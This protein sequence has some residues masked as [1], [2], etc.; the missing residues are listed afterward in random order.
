MPGIER[1]SIDVLMHVAQRCVEL[2]V[3][4]IALLPVIDPALKTPDG[5]AALDADGLIVRAVREI[6]QRFPELG[7]LTDVAL[8]PYTSHGQ[9]G[10]IDENGYVLNHETVAQ[11]VAQARL[12]AEAGVDIVA[13]SD[14][15]D[16]RIGAI[17]AMLESTGQRH[18]RIMAYAA[19]YA[20]AFYGPFRDAIG[21]ASNL[22]RGN[23]M[24][25]QMDPANS[26]EAL[27]EVAFDISEGADMV[28]VKPGMPYLD[29]VRRVK[30]EFHFPTYAYQINITMKVITIAAFLAVTSL[31][32]V[33]AGPVNPLEIHSSACP[34]NVLS[35]SQESS[36]VG[37][38]CLPDMGLLVLVQQW[39]PGLGPADEFTMHGIW[40]NTCDGA[41]GGTST[42]C[43]SERIFCDVEHR[44][45]QF[46]Q[47]HD[48]VPSNF[49]KNMHDYWSSC[50]GDN[51][52]FW[53]H[54]WSKHGTCISTLGPSCWNQFVQNEDVY[55][56]FSKGLALRSKYNLYKALAKADI[57]PGST[58][59][60]D[61]IHK[62]IKEAFGVDAE[63][64]CDDNDN[65]NEIYLYLNVQNRDQYNLTDPVLCSGPE[66]RRDPLPRPC[67]NLHVA[68]CSP[69]DK[70]CRGN[71]NYP[72]K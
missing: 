69:A 44:L 25:Y 23:K 12:Q 2:G 66:C 72:R 1:V 21:S 30:D 5:S 39:S 47:A 19:K 8:D 51:N 57:L 60:I 37:P 64:W 41:Q 16:G 49:M 58:P 34:P 22:G 14:M 55:N 13:P 36:D 7:V 6:K 26:D 17:R 70:R 4:V 42:G 63:I 20:S 10:L 52:A 35:C 53:S 62:A 61:D 27:R 31:S 9:D 18:T 59:H 54:E 56:Y 48:I 67:P 43:D 24:A 71:I 32:V 45:E 38:C 11:L 29:V 3:P 50:N 68:H 40:P 15:M 46:S 65:L 28:M 33:A